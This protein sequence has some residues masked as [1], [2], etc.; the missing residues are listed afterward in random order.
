MR[1][2]ELLV[3]SVSAQAGGARDPSEQLGAREQARTYLLFCVYRSADNRPLSGPGQLG[4]AGLCP[5]HG[6]QPTAGGS[7]PELVG[8]IRV[9]DKDVPIA[10]VQD[11]LVRPGH[12]RRGIVTRPGCSS[13]LR[14][15]LTLWPAARV[16]PASRLR[17][18]GGQRIAPEVHGASPPLRQRI[19]RIPQAGRRHRGHIVGRDPSR[20]ASRQGA[21]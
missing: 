8:L 9:V 2:V 20:F 19:V 10:Y 21:P 1:E 17:P 15:S 11:L 7:E 12:Q 16:R 18:A 14:P 6:E 3:V 13:M 5:A 4:T